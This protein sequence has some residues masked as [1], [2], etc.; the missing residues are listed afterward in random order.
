MDEKSDALII[1]TFTKG[2][3]PLQNPRQLVNRCRSNATTSMAHSKLNVKTLEGSTTLLYARTTRSGHG[4]EDETDSS[5]SPYSDRNNSCLSLV[6]QARGGQCNQP[7][8]PP[9][10]LS[11][12]STYLRVHVDDDPFHEAFG[13]QKLTRNAD[14]YRRLFFISRQHPYLASNNP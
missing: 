6:V 12:N 8:F 13:P 11:R 2:V 4:R 10:E 7:Y 3:P 5:T 9:V 1:M 14:V